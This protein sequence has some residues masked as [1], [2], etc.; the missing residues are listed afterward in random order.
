MPGSTP[1]REIPSPS[2]TDTPPSKRAKT[3]SDKD[4]GSISEGARPGGGTSG[5][6]A[7]NSSL[8]STQRSAGLVYTLEAVMTGSWFIES[9]VRHIR[10]GCNEG[11]FSSG[12]LA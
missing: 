2:S 1:A 9:G 5:T 7:C 11:F 10:R 4:R 3:S 12:K 8:V 6:V